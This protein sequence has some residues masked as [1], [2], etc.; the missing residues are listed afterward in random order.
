MRK[1]FLLNFILFLFS[2]QSVWAIT[3]TGPTDLFTTGI[4]DYAAVSGNSEASS[5]GQVIEVLG[6]P[7]GSL[8]SADPESETRILAMGLL[9]DT[10][11]D[12]GVTAATSLVFGFGLNETGRLGSNYVTITDLDM[13]FERAGGGSSDFSLGS[14]SITV[15]N[16]T[17]GQST[18]E[19][20][21]QV[22]L[23]F[24]FMTEYSSL[25]TEEF[26]IFSSIGNTSDGFEIYFLSSAF[27]ISPIPEPATMLL[28]GSGLLGL[29]G[30]GRKKFFKK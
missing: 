30:F 7:G 28:L 9:Y 16:Y 8:Q 19:A 22:D 27:T 1:F 20:R 5:P 11:A 3:I 12:G 26:E 13:S 23:G 4:G 24:D 15:Y 17:Q 29:A 6:G 21:I 2:V 14:D 25:S 18:A 10:L